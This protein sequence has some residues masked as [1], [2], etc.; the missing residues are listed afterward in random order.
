MDGDLWVDPGTGAP[1]YAK[2]G[3]EDALW[4]AI[5]EKAYAILRADDSNYTSINAGDGTLEIGKAGGGHINLTLSYWG[6]NDGVTKEA[7]LDWIARGSP[8]DDPIRSARDAG[9][10]AFLSWVQQERAQGAALVTGSVS[11]VSDTAALTATSWRRSAHILM[12]DRVET[13]G[14]SR[15]VGIVLRNPYG[16]EAPLTDYTQIYFLLGGAGRWNLP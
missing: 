8:Q 7:V 1:R 6:Y 3:G 15:P 9:V 5:V 4:V 10:N 12:I 11:N 13:N 2:L 14:A 16:F